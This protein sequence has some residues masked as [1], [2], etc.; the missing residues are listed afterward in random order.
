VIELDCI[1]CKQA[2]PNVRDGLLAFLKKFPDWTDK[3]VAAT[4]EVDMD[5]V[6]RVRAHV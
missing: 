6:R 3:Q 4:F 5:T 2:I 1:T